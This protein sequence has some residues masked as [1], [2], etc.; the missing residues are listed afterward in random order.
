[1]QTAISLLPNHVVGIYEEMKGEVERRVFEID[2]K[3]WLKKMM[4]DVS[5]EEFEEIIGVADYVRGAGRKNL[6]NGFYTRSL[7]TV[8]GWIQDLKI[9]R[10]R[11][12]GFQPSCLEKKHGRRQEV[13]N[14]LTMECFRRGVSTRDVDRIL[15]ALCGVPISASSVSRLTATWDHDVKAWHQRELSDE[16]VYLMFDGIWI[17]NRSLGKIRRLILVAYG[18]KSDGSREIIDY[19]F[20]GS[21]KEENW[22]KFLTNL[23]YRGVEG[24]NLQLITTDGCVGLANAIAIVYPTIPHQ[25]CW[26]HKMR[27]ILKSVKKDDAKL[28]QQ[29]LSP[30]FRENDWTEKKAMSLIKGWMKSWKAKYPKAVLCL[31]RDLEKLLLYLACDPK[32]HKAIRTSNHIERQFKEYRRRMKP[33]EIT[34]NRDSAD[35]ILY[36]LTMI[37]NDK[38][39][40]Y[41]IAFTHKTLH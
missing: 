19:M 11:L 15:H 1:M 20:T 22:L 30:L 3:G 27:N 24:K 12:G 9:P 4:E 16:Y 26:A 31:E 35:R 21:E 29:G 14:R 37:R 41:P 38:L 34:P 36:S 39:K 25:L 6:R 2:Y 13:L 10:P 7:D 33:M 18:I 28:V 23:H 32:H 40:R 17:K 5:V 8:F